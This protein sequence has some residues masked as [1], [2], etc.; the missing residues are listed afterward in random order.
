[1]DAAQI[2]VIL[3]KWRQGG[4]GGGGDRRGAGGALSPFGLVV[5]QVVALEGDS[6]LTGGFLDEDEGSVVV[7]E[8]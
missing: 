7:V 5:E 4:D 8:A 1:M 3:F 6:L 2:G